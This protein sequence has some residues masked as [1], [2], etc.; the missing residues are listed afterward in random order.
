MGTSASSKGPASKVPFD[1]PWLDDPD[2]TEHDQSDSREETDAD[3]PDAD[4]TTD[5][6]NQDSADIAPLGRFNQSRR[7]IGKYA[8]E[9][10]G[11]ESFQKAAGQYSNTGMGGAGRLASRMQSSA[12]TGARAA[13]FLGGVA[14]RSNSETNSWV[15]KITSQNLSNQQI[16]DLIIDQVAPLGGTRDEESCSHSMAQALSDFLE[17]NEDSDLL[18]L[19]TVEIHDITERFLANEAYNRLINDIGQVFES[20]NLSQR[21]AF[22]RC[23][24]MREYLREDISVQI[25]ALWA[26][27][28]NPSQA[29]LT[30]L[31]KS[32]IERTF[33]IYESE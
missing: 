7:N 31:L 26:I 16:I 23:E 21:E 1:P 5:Q 14:S 10:G 24:E 28:S 22:E 32:A 9:G 18:D 33:L 4:D 30:G 6:D 25:E 11:R 2:G 8:R 17:E 13:T 19:E 20:Q 29:Q 12:D 27:N 15:D 3:S